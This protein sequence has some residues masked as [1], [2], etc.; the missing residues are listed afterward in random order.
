MFHRPSIKEYAKQRLQFGRGAAILVALLTAL[1]ATGSSAPSFSFNFNLGSESGATVNFPLDGEE[2]A[3]FVGVF[4]VLM[5]FIMLFASLY[6]IFLG[7]VIY[8]GSRGWHLRY[9]RGENPTVGAMFDSFRIYKPAVVTSLVKNIYLFLWSCLFFVPGIIKGYSYSMTEYIMYENP[10]LTANQAITLSRRLTDGNK[11]ALFVFDL[12]YFGW[13]MLN[14][15]TFGILGIV[16]V[17]PYRFTAH[18][19]VY[20]VMK[21]QAI[22]SGRMTWAD[23]GQLPP[24]YEA[25]A[26][27]PEQPAPFPPQN[28]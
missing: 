18:A 8:V 26:P 6:S 11:W 17:N 20:Q 7:N 10:N 14:A 22:L 12:S 3:I 24:V 23:F 27:A 15:L 28:F 4:V 9:W 2:A 5:F 1:L 19:G 25:P 16:Y 21:D 13:D